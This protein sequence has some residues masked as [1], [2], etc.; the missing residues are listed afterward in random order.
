MRTLKNM[1]LAAAA[2]SALALAGCGG[3]GGGGSASAPKP[4][5]VAVPFTVPAAFQPAAGTYNIAAGGNVVVDGVQ[6]NCAGPGA[7][8]VIVDATGMASSLG[9]NVTA[10]KSPSLAA[11][12]ADL[13]AAEARVAAAE[14][15]QAA[16]EARAT[17]AEADKAAA[18]AAQ[19]AAEAAQA[20]AEAAQAAAEAAR[21]TAEADAEA[22]RTAQAAAEAAQAAAEAAQATAEAAQAAAEAAQ[23]T[24][25]AE[26]EAA[27][28]AQAAAEAEA[29]AARTAQRAAEENTA[30]AR[31]RAAAAEAARVEAAAAKAAAEAEAEAAR[32]AQMEAEAAQAAAEE[33]QRTAEAARMAAETARMAAEA[34]KTAAEA[35]QMAAEEAKTA[36]E[37][38]KAAAEER[39][40]QA[41]AARMAA[42]EAK[43]VAEEALAKAE[44]DRR[45]A[46]EEQQQAMVRA[47]AR[48]LYN[49]ISAPTTGDI[50]GGTFGPNDRVGAYN[51]AE[52]H[53]VVSIGDGTNT[54]TAV[55]ATLSEDKDATVADNHGWA[56]KRYADPAGGDSYEAVVYSNVEAPKMGR[57]FGST[58]AVTTTGAFE[59]QLN[60]AG[61][62]ALTSGTNDGENVAFTGVTRT[63]GTETFKLPDPNPGGAVTITIPGSY[64]GVSGTYSCTPADAAAGCS[65]AVAAKGFTVSAGDTWVFTPSN[66]NARVRDAADTSYASYGWW[67][68]KSENGNTFT[69]SAFH[70]FKGT[71]GTVDITD[72]VGGTATYMGGAAGKYA[73]QSGTGGTND[74]G[75]FTAR[76]TLE[77]NFEDDTITGTIDQFTG[78]DGESRD[79]SVELKEA[80]ITPGD[81]T[82]ARTDDNDTVWTIGG[83]AGTA[84]GEWSGNLREEG[85]DGVPKVAT[86]TFYSEYG[87]TGRMVGAFGA[88][89]Q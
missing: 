44:E 6:Y 69:A 61:A 3:G 17:S 57:K 40:R 32:T 46:E 72:L 12:D 76:A 33:A 14:A 59:Y 48:K 65:A 50:A 27:R 28:T 81:G 9:G 74:A 5:N 58:A 60:A 86:G 64:H 67:L 62:L 29:E 77:A 88:N 20:T 37:E 7:C 55:S 26:A 87:T 13:A 4:T 71:P 38:D 45:L 63:A 39:A 83:N 42:E 66:A 41:E 10:T 18:E 79:W 54:P 85:T 84:S 49:G 16:A 51:T 73:L 8:T 82:I 75:H 1:A 47:D 34:A 31:A 23:A 21:A 22:A 70:D 30:E 80:A 56:G 68:H 25:E 35:A 24:A 11:Y 78:A 53:I 43:R 36:A 89:K 2:A 19:A 52:T 15:A